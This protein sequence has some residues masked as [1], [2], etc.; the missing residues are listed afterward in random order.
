VEIDALAVL[1]GF[2]PSLVIPFVWF[3][4]LIVH[5]HIEA[6]ETFVC[7]LSAAFEVFFL[8][9]RGKAVSFCCGRFGDHI[10]PTKHVVKVLLQQ[11][12]RVADFSLKTCSRSTT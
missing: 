2:P 11:L 3:V 12:Q 8:C 7:G 1:F 9:P 10:F 5:W 6:M 4:S